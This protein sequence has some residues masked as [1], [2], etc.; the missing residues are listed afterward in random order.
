MLFTVNAGSSELSLFEINPFDPYRPRHIHNIDTMG[1]FPMSVDY[2]PK[3]RQACVLNGG[4]RAGISCF[5]V[6]LLGGMRPSGPLRAFEKSLYNQ[7]KYASGDFNTT[8]QILFNPDS[9]GVFAT[10][11]GNGFFPPYTPGSL[12]AWP[13]KNG[14][15][16]TGPYVLNQF[17]D[18]HMDFG[19]LF[20]KKDRVMITDPSSGVVFMDI[21]PDLKASI[22]VHTVIENNLL[23]C[24]TAWSPELN[25][26]YSMDGA[27]NQI[28]LLNPQTGAYFANITVKPEV[29]ANYS[30]PKEGTYDAIIARNGILYTLAYTNGMYAVDTKTRKQIQYYDLSFMGDRMHWQGLAQWPEQRLPV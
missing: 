7:T 3:L 9:T 17:D 19:F 29:P 6:D 23:S 8:G 4:T 15:V 11:K 22:F 13:I 1:D 2:S 21:A 25:T 14:K 24:W 5:T 28:Y 16:S 10:I 30:E 20:I 12:V 26:L 18:I 27:K